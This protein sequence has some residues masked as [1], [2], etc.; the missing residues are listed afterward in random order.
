MTGQVEISVMLATFRRAHILERTLESLTH[1]NPHTPPWELI[2]VD[3]A[4]EP[5]TQ[6]VASRFGTRLPLTFM[7]HTQPGKNAALNAALSVARGSLLVFTDDDVLAHVDWLQELWDG[8]ARWPEHAIFGGRILPAFPEPHPPFDL[9]NRNIIQAFAVADWQ[10]D[11]GIIPNVFVYGPNMAL[12]RELFD[13]GRRF[14]ESLYAPERKF[15]MAD[16]SSFLLQMQGIGHR[17]IY[18]PRALVNHQVRPEQLELAWLIDRAFRSGRTIAEHE[19]TRQHRMLFGLPRYVF[20]E[21]L[22]HRIAAFCWTLRGKRG[23]WLSAYMEHWYW[24]GKYH[25]YRIQQASR[26]LP[27]SRPLE[28]Q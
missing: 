12:R 17:A 16:E 5:A 23:Q 1:Q 18:L 9:R 7:T 28:P 14:D 11:E 19:R 6:A 13:E 27:A 24:R 10:Q 20:S 25:Q 26:S 3:N 8:A 2:I 22:W 4:G 21:L 15:M